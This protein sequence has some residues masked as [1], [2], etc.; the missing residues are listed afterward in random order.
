MSWILVIC[1]VA[2]QV[3]TFMPVQS[4]SCSSPGQPRFLNQPS[5]IVVKDGGNASFTCSVSDYNP[6]TDSL[7]WK[8]N[9]SIFYSLMSREFNESTHVMTST[10]TFIKVNRTRQM[11]QCVLYILNA[12]GQLITCRSRIATISIL[13]FP[14]EKDIKCGPKQLE[15]LQ[16]GQVVQ[17]W[18]TV[19]LGNP[20]VKLK[21]QIPGSEETLDRGYQEHGIQRATQDVHVSHL[22][23]NRTATCAATSSLAFPNQQLKC[24]IGP[25]IVH[26]KPVVTLQQSAADASFEQGEIIQIKCTVD[27]FPYVTE[28]FWLCTPPDAVACT[29]SGNTVVIDSSQIHMNTSLQFVAKCTARNQIGVTEA[30]SNMTIL[31][32]SSDSGN[33]VCQDYSLIVTQLN[34]AGHIFPNAGW[35]VTFLCSVVGPKFDVKRQRF[36]WYYDNVMVE[37]TSVDIFPMHGKTIGQSAMQLINVYETD[38]CKHVTCDFKNENCPDMLSA[39]VSLRFNQESLCDTHVID[40]GRNVSLQLSKDHRRKGDQF[41]EATGQTHA[42]RNTTPQVDTMTNTT[43]SMRFISISAGIVMIAI[44]TSLVS[45]LLFKQLKH[46]SRTASTGHPETDYN[47]ANTSESIEQNTTETPQRSSIELDVIYEDPKIISCVMDDCC[48]LSINAETDYDN[49]I[50]HSCNSVSSSDN[51][52]SSVDSW[53]SDFGE[54]SSSEVPKDTTSDSTE[55]SMLH[56]VYENQTMGTINQGK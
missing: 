44:I 36:L 53:I 55:D 31:P 37:N 51:Q 15:V 7:L 52:T 41:I 29:V 5:D 54:D 6:A 38:N 50:F 14:G 30:S 23:H 1:A 39:T 21:W 10:I 45:I 11:Q 25:F 24:S 18:C 4:A 35:N 13:H 3:N 26:Y 27:A 20:P 56:H 17:M 12:K 46:G 43:L 8:V 2:L 47:D 16:N 9:P 42:N 19:P 40:D 34:K 28:L 32:S 48:I 22:I 49:K 33:N